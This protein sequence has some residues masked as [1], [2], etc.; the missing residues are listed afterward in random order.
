MRNE[1]SVKLDQYWSNTLV[2]KIEWLLAYG[3]SW[4]WR[5]VI[6]S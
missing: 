6:V 3:V 5:E 4:D 1:I 2:G